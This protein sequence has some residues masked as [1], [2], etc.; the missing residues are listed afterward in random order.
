MNPLNFYIHPDNLDYEKD[1]DPVGRD[2]IKQ[3]NLTDF[4]RTTMYCSGHF[5]DEDEF[6]WGQRIRICFS[7][8]NYD[9][10]IDKLSIIEYSLFSN[11]FKNVLRPVSIWDYI[12]H[13][14]N[15]TY[16]IGSIIIEYATKEERQKIINILK[17][18]L[19]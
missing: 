8:L 3:I 7:I 5:E 16:M 4:M 9:K 6:T 15:K 2:L 11:G 1:I 10:A 19:A 17:E 12:D 18:I 13:D 14:D